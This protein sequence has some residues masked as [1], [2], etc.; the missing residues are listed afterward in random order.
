MRKNGLHGLK[1]MMKSAK[2]FFK[3]LW[4]EMKILQVTPVFYPA[5]A[6]GGIVGV[7]CEISKKLAEIGRKV[8][9]YTTDANKDSRINDNFNMRYAM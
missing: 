8:T 1:G 6:Y 2:G 7:T 3:Y 5:T 4:R 9:V